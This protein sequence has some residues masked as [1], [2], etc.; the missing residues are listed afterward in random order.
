MKI[1]ASIH[2]LVLAS[3]LAIG[4]SGCENQ[5]VDQDRRA[6]NP[7][8][9]S[10]Q[11]VEMV[12][13][14][15]GCELAC[16]GRVYLE[17]TALEGVADIDFV[18]GNTTDDDPRDRAHVAYD[19]ALT[20]PDEL[21][22]AIETMGGG[23]FRVSASTVLDSAAASATNVKAALAPKEDHRELALPKAYAHYELPNFFEVFSRLFN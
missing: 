2:H 20:S 17:L 15:M 5:A 7:A 21:A 3:V 12:I 18:F 10:M 19:P 8:T 22:R 6:A 23:A 11:T 16:A 9:T 4:L 1:G 14:G 13:E